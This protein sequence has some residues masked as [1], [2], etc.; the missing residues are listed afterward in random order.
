MMNHAKAT[1]SILRSIEVRDMFM[2][3]RCSLKRV[4]CGLTALSLLTI[5]LVPLTNL[6]AD[7]A[8]Q[9]VSMVAAMAGT[10]PFSIESSLIMTHNQF[11]DWIKQQWGIQPAIHLGQ[12]SPGTGIHPAGLTGSTPLQASLRQNAYILGAGDAIS[13][14]VHQ[15]N[16]F[17]REHIEIGTD[18]IVSMPWIGEIQASGKTRRAVTAEIEEAL[19][20]YLVDP[21]VDLVVAKTR[22]PITYVLG[23]IKHPG[24]YMQM[25]KEANIPDVREVIVSTDYHLSTALANAG[26][27]NDSADLRNIHVIN[28]ATGQ[29]KLVNLMALLLT[30]QIDQ[31]LILGPSDVVYVPR[32]DAN[33][34]MDPDA[35]KLIARSNIG[36]HTL[37]VRIYGLVREPNIY[38][39]EP[40]QM[41]LQAL[42]AKA[43]GPLPDANIQN[44]FVA[45]TQADGTLK[46]LLANATSEDVMLKPNDV[47]MV[48]DTRRINKINR[49]FIMIAK[50]LTPV[51]QG[52]FLLRNVDQVFPNFIN[53][54]EIGL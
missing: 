16:R 38:N 50:L 14:N 35:L 15:D 42:L 33:T 17:S 20:E 28:T 1:L 11:E 9:P 45:R 39:L 21:E 31:D 5:M 49:V 23:A 3:R 29:H 46:K 30:G 18:G 41:S 22:R 12:K 51:V 48:T 53:D 52:S 13:V 26:G 47:V 54:A 7:A 25:A 6:S 43:K 2:T 19:K 8:K 34:Q 44:I 24:P 37:P 40:E 27:V 36:S 10:N 4:W 32:I